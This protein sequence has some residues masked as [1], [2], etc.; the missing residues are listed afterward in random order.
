MQQFWLSNSDERPD[1]SM[2]VYTIEK[3]LQV[4]MIDL[5]FLY[6]KKLRF[7]NMQNQKVNNNKFF[8]FCNFSLNQIIKIMLLKGH[9]TALRHIKLI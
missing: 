3:S 4:I 8:V 2:I 7:Y 5:I 6:A 9:G 1:F